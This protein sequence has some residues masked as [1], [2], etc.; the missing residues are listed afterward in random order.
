MDAVRESD[1]KRVVLKQVNADSDERKIAS[2]LYNEELCQD[3]RNHSVPILEVLQDEQPGIV[4]LVMPCLR[5]V[6]EPPLVSVRD[7]VD[8]VHQLLEV[9]LSSDFMCVA[10]MIW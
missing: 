3:S 7:V 2:M 9:F 5:P 4:Y 10:L 8:F 6:D 1:G